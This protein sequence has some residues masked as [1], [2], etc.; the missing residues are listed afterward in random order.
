MIVVTGVPRSRTSLVMQ[1]LKLLGV[2][3]VGEKYDYRNI[4]KHNQKGYWELPIEKTLNG[5]KTE[6]YR[7]KGIKLFGESLSKTDPCYISKIIWCIRYR[8]YAVKSFKKLLMDNPN[9]GLK[10]TRKNCEKVYDENF[11]RISKSITSKNMEY[12]RI[13]YKDWNNPKKTIKRIV[14]YLGLENVNIENA[15]DNVDL[16]KGG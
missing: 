15:I 16:G 10:A 1:S 5:I 12:M 7:G 14:D 3:I 11:S 8:N 9:F 6:E 4:P 2:D 13:D